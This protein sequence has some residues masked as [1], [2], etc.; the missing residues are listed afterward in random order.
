LEDEVMFVV[1]RLIAAAALFVAAHFAMGYVN[2]SAG[3]SGGALIFPFAT[4]APS[5]WAFGALDGG[6]FVLLI[7]VMIG[8]A[9]IAVLAFFLGVLATFGALVPANLWRPLVLIGV[10]CSVTLLVLHPS[11]WVLLPLALNAGL[12]W[13]AWTS[14]WTPS[15]A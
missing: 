14:A 6:P 11:V 12:A 1:E 7:P 5:R 3:G 10:A 13:V 8:L 4:D 15:A 2:S 9:G